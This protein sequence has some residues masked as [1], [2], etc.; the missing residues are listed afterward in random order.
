MFNSDYVGLLGSLQIWLNRKSKKKSFEG[1]V[2]GNRPLRV[3]CGWIEKLCDTLK[4]GDMIE[5]HAR[6]ANV[7]SLVGNSSGTAVETNLISP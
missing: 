5:V 4:C 3:L 6:K 7:S 2:F 1:Y